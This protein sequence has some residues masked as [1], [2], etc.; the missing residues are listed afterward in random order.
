MVLKW[1]P[2]P[3]KSFLAG[4]KKETELECGT[5]YRWRVRARDEAGNYSAWSA[6]SEFSLKLD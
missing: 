2:V 6:W 1:G 5:T 3:G 4:A